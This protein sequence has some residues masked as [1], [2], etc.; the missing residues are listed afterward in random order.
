MF[1]IRYAQRLGDT[2]AVKWADSMTKNSLSIVGRLL[3]ESA[4]RKFRARQQV[5]CVVFVDYIFA[6]QGPSRLRV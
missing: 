5:A 1:L 3:A 4:L 2:A 6:R